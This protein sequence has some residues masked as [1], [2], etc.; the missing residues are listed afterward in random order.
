MFPATAVTIH[1]YF[2]LFWCV[3]SPGAGVQVGAADRARGHGDGLGGQQEPQLGLSH[4]GVPAD[5]E[6]HRTGSFQVL[7]AVASGDY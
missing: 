3:S 5:G 4:L 2:H 7:A 1:I 6:R